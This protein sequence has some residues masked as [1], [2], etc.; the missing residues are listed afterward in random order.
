MGGFLFSRSPLFLAS[1]ALEV[2]RAASGEP[3]L[4]GLTQESINPSFARE[5]QLL[6][7]PMS[8]AA[9]L[10]PPVENEAIFN[11]RL[12]SSTQVHAWFF[13]KKVFVSDCSGSFWPPTNFSLEKCNYFYFTSGYNLS[14]IF[15][16]LGLPAENR[17]RSAQ[18]TD[19][20]LY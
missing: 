8:V 11:H 15:P 3:Y 12:T 19:M 18:D 2:L 4:H 20:L 1:L 7:K 14:N 17:V 10:C 6:G 5:K 9:S 16:Q 13:S